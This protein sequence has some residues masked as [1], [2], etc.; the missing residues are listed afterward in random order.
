LYSTRTPPRPRAART[1]AAALIAGAFALGG[2][3]KAKP[4]DAV[5]RGR[6]IYFMGCI[7]CHNADPN[8][9]GRQG[10]AVAGSSRALLQARLLHRAYPPSYKP[11]RTTHIM[12]AFPDLSARDVDD[13]AVYLTA[14]T[15]PRQ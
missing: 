10:P 9:P 7:G 13:L 2:C 14:A 5:Q 6:T 8:R 15:T 1:I 3:G 4:S 11:K 12:S